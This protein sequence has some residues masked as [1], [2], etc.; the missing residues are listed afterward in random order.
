MQNGVIK[1]NDNL[2]ILHLEADKYPESSLEKLKNFNFIQREIN[3]QSELENFLEKNQFEVI[4]TRLG[5]NISK[6]IID[7]Q[8]SLKIIV[9]PTTGLN[10][11]SYTESNKNNLKIISLKG[12]Y[13]FLSTIK[14]T[15]EHTWALLMTL[16]RRI[17]EL[18]DTVKNGFWIREN[19]MADE[20]NG[21]NLGIIGYGRLGKIVANYGKSFGM[22]VYAYDINPKAFEGAQ[23]IKY[24][25]LEELLS[26]SDFIVLMINY[27]EENEKFMDSKKFSLMKKGSYFINT[28]RGELVDEDDLFLA[29]NESKFSG[30]ALDVLNNDSVWENKINGSYKLIEYMNSHNNLIITPHTGGYGKTSI[31]KTREFI[32]NKLLNYLKDETNYYS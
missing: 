20:L 30:V 6:E 24:N 7:N 16:T 23:N 15:A 10:H 12:E 2:R 22:N 28:S 19:M 14:S 3:T 18:R 11:I 13:E 26:I 25:N 17:I 29:L 1:K 31:L 8:K 32:T 9:T 21:K 5:L 27:S 4:I